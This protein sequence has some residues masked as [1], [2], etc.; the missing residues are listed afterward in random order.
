ML[1][2]FL[3]SVFCATLVACASR[4][5]PS[6]VVTETSVPHTCSG[7]PIDTTFASK[8]VVVSDLN[9]IHPEVNVRQGRTPTYPPEL[10]DSRIQGSV[11][12]SF[13][14]EPDG[15]V[16]LPS[17]VIESATHPAFA[18]SVC[19]ALTRMRFS[20][21]VRDGRRVPSR[22]LSMAFQFELSY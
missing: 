22:V 11:R 2:L 10:R 19:D 7:K 12:A 3:P 16:S 17:V 9:E 20:A 5:T 13:T 15:S 14:V 21:L 4:S 1:R 8:A 6:L 18:R